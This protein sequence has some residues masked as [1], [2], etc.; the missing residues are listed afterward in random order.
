MSD[1]L[2]YSIMNNTSK[3]HHSNHTKTVLPPISSITSQLPPLVP[4]SN[5]TLASPFGTPNNN[6]I[7]LP[8]LNQYYDRS[9]TT[10]NT[11]TTYT[12]GLTTPSPPPLKYSYSN[13]NLTEA[14]LSKFE[15]SRNS[16]GL[17]LLSSA[18]L[19]QQQTNNLSLATPPPSLT[20][21][22]SS[23][24]SSSTPSSPYM[25]DGTVTKPSIEQPTISEPTPI[26]TTTTTTTTKSQ[27]QNKRRQR[28]GPSC[29]SCRVRKVKCDAEIQVINE[30]AITTEYSFISSSEIDEI[31]SGKRVL[32]SSGSLL[33]SNNSN[34]NAKPTKIELIFSHGKFIKFKS[35]QNC[36]CKLNVDCCFKN[37][38]TK[39]DILLNKKLKNSQSTAS[40]TTITTNCSSISNITTTPTTTTTGGAKKI[41]KKKLQKH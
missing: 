38:Y 16:H 34:N 31:K 13:N 36:T 1:L 25:N 11:N 41:M 7:N 30:D 35:C 21:R 29:D 20:S 26:T 4:S 39:E 5:T 40:G 33:T 3:Y 17:G 12:N 18:V 8:A 24:S 22:T 2:S 27:A 23:I 9:Y 6:N 37:G 10:T 19:Y 15:T 14:N 32:L 28:L